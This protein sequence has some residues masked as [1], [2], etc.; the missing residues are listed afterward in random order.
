MVRHVFNGKSLIEV[1]KDELSA[2]IVVIENADPIM[3]QLRTA[4]NSS[5]QAMIS[6]PRMMLQ[7][8]HPAASYGNIH[9]NQHM[10]TYC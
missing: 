8:V 2:S 3:I 7:P 1:L 10:C 6:A 9:L 5:S 4:S